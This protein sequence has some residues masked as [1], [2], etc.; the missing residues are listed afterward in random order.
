MSPA[1]GPINAVVV[2]VVV[3]TAFGRAP[4]G[5][6]ETCEGVPNLARWAHASAGSEA[7]GGAPY[8]ATER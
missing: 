5:V 4:Y 6:N 7:F 2:T 8:G 1:K 3:C